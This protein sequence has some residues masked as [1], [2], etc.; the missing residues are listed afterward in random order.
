MLQTA[1]RRADVAHLV[2]NA[3]EVGGLVQRALEH[4]LITRDQAEALLAEHGPAALPLLTSHVHERLDLWSSQYVADLGL[5]DQP[6][7]VSQMSVHANSHNDNR[8][9]VVADFYDVADASSLASCSGRVRRRIVEALRKM[10]LPV[11]FA[12]DLFG[13]D[14]GPWSEITSMLARMRGSASP[15]IA[16][17]RE[18]WRE[19]QEY[20]EHE[21][22]DEGEE[23]IYGVGSF[24]EFVGMSRRYLESYRRTYG[25]RAASNRVAERRWGDVARKLERI[26][27]KVAAW[28]FYSHS[29]PSDFMPIEN[30]YVIST[31]ENDDVLINH[32][33]DHHMDQ[34]NGYEE[35]PGISFVMD[36]AGLMRAVAFAKLCAGVFH[37][38]QNEANAR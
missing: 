24:E 17:L 23:F 16:R 35:M 28:D 15:S 36:D 8:V 30:C 7:A 33:M 38:I 18:V 4:E 22:N 9:D 13:I 5:P 34:F 3:H 10:Q 26:A 6:K 31:G 11:V 29:E 27:P 19:T 14:M 25:R 37:L 20:F 12:V 2:R 21:V 1:Q 32:H